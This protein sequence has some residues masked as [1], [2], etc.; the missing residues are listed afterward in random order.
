MQVDRSLSTSDDVAE[1]S[2]DKEKAQCEVH[3]D[4]F[5]ATA[6]IAMAQYTMDAI[7][8]EQS[9]RRDSRSA[10][11]RVLAVTHTHL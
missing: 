6:Q 9:L 5:L 3:E 8:T 2:G 11:H 4:P 7:H 1:C 10:I